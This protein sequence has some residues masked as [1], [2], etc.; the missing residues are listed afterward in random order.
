[1]MKTKFWRPE[2]KN[3]Q[4]LIKASNNNFKPFLKQMLN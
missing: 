3:W 1:M 2:M 4:I